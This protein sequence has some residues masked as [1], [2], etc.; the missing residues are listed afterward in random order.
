MHDENCRGAGGP[1]LGWGCEGWC[2]KALASRPILPRD[3]CASGDVGKAR[4]SPVLLRYEERSI[5]MS[6]NKEKKHRLQ[7]IG[8]RSLKLLTEREGTGMK[9]IRTVR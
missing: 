6:V 1:D 8:V 2:V 3:C 5:Q 7:V 9:I 4:H